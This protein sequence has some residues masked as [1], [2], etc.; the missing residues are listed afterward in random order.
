MADPE[1]I[2]EP[3]IKL[4]HELDTIFGKRLQSVS[5]YGGNGEA[6][7]LTGGAAGEAHG[8]VHTLVI[9]ESIDASDL[10]ACANLASTWKRRGLA[11]PLLIPG[12]ELARSLDAFPLELGEIL[13]HHRVVFGTDVLA[14]LTV[15]PAD[16][17]RACEVQARSH[18]LHLREG[19]IQAAAQPRELGAI[20]QASARPFRLLLVSMARLEGVDVTDAA[21][22]AGHLEAT[23]GLTPGV[24]QQVLAAGGSKGIS[25][26]D[27]QSLYPA[28]IHV[29]ERLV[30]YVDAWQA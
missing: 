13:A 4:L 5:I 10:R 15:A 1:T 11:T 23:V 25:A 20:I 9:V 19:Y 8:H 29:V 17:R 2:P 30:H 28:Y 22:F 26:T 12:S 18:L 7:A 14:G 24:V 6:E 16:I 3:V 27:A 21:R